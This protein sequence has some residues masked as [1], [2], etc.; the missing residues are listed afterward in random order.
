MSCQ[1]LCRS[2]NCVL[3]INAA[4]LLEMF[5][6]YGFKFHHKAVHSDIS[7]RLIKSNDIRDESKQLV[8]LAKRNHE[9]KEAIISQPNHRLFFKKKG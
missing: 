4:P 7:H 2:E 5:G 9:K 1:Y 8:S 3:I 6:V